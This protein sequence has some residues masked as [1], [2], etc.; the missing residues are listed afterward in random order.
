M[1]DANI[2][3]GGFWDSNACAL[4][5]FV[6]AALQLCFKIINLNLLPRI[7]VCIC[8]RVCSDE[9][10]FKDYICTVAHGSV[11]NLLTAAARLHQIFNGLDLH[12]VLGSKRHSWRLAAAALQDQGEIVRPLSIVLIP[13]GGAAF[14]QR[15]TLRPRAK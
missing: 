6:A 4:Q 15:A 5:N 11:S 14:P 1:S 9:I 12:S 7:V 13:S 3:S 10:H 8:F 2:Y